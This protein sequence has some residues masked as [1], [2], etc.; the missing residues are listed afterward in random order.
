MSDP[1]LVISGACGFRSIGPARAVMDGMTD[2]ILNPDSPCEM[3]GNPT[4]RGVNSPFCSITCERKA[5]SNYRDPFENPPAGTVIPVTIMI[6]RRGCPSTRHAV[7]GIMAPD[8]ISQGREWFPGI[9]LPVQGIPGLSESG[10]AEL[11]GIVEYRINEGGEWSGR[12]GLLNDEDDLDSAFA[13]AYV[14]HPPQ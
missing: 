2:P 5:I 6:K 7:T 3:C 12:G 8:L 10:L 1:C 13:Y 9:M 4:I 14:A 11:F